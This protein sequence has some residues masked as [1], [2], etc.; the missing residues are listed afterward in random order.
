[1]PNVVIVHTDDTGQYIEPYGH[2]VPTPNLQEMA[3]EGVCFRNAFCAAPTCSPSRGAMLS[4]Q[5]P[6]SNGLIGLTHR[7]FAMDNYGQH[8]VRHLSRNGFETALCGQQHEAETPERA[9]REKLG[10]DVLPED[11]GADGSFVAPH[12]R[13]E[14]DYA[15]ARAAAEYVRSDPDE[16][17]FLSLGLY[18]THREFPTDDLAVDPD[19]V[20]PPD[21][22]QDV[23]AA[24]EDMA[25]YVTAAG[26]VDDCIGHVLDALRD[27]GALDDTLVLFTT[28][29]GLPFPDMKCNLF[30]GGIAVSL[31]ARF[32]DRWRG[33]TRDA[34]VSQID[35][36][37]TLCECLGVETPDWVQ[38]HSVL[39]LLRG[40]T[41]AVRDA[42][43]SEVTYHAAYEP[44]RAV[45]TERYKYIRRF[46][47]EY[48]TYV[49]ANVDDSPLKRYLL[50]RGL[51][52]RHRPREA[53]YDLAFDPNERENL[54]D[55]PAYEAVYDDL[56]NRLETWMVDTGDPLVE[57]SV[58]KP[59]G[60]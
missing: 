55:D 6:H 48:E 26:F 56:S 3:E 54:V 4:G 31:L 52:D 35:L 10:Y 30:D 46:D 14:R 7:G 49:L 39:P 42:V 51:G 60:A 53:L 59:D 33:V 25:G 13:A 21:P 29:H 11:P 9:T 47:A 23:P 5:A 20:R 19:Y 57:E 12:E 38:G 1:M 36:Y 22:I 17:Y 50:E 15:N 40:E 32:P 24:R 8:L 44:K 41:D 18:N 37:P 43:F 28:D 2:D 27:S 16:P 45:R 34:L 58:P